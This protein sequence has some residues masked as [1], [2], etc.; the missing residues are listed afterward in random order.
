MTPRTVNISEE[1][2]SG[3]L[4]S[5]AV[6]NESVMN[7]TK[8][9]EK[10]ESLLYGKDSDGGLVT[11][12]NTMAHTIEDQQR[13][14]DRLEKS[15][16]QVVSFM[17]SQLEI[18]KQQQETNRVLNK[19]LYGLAGLVFLILLLIGVADISALHNLLSGVKIP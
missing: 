18:N 7:L 8:I 11:R 13:A 1:K 2:I 4:A 15:C 14:L 9:S 10:H 3:L 12:G 17:E 19:V 16:T 6:T 5:L